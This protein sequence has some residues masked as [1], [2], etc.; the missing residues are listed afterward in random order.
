MLSRRQAVGFFKAACE[1]GQVGEPST[2]CDFAD[3]PMRLCRIFQ[4]SPAARKPP[5]LNE[6]VKRGIYLD[7]SGFPKGA[8]AVRFLGTYRSAVNRAKRVALTK[9]PSGRTSK[10]ALDN[11][12]PMEAKLVTELQTGPGWPFE[13]KWDGFRCLAAKQRNSV[14][15]RGKSGKSLSRYFPEMVEAF[16]VL[17]QKA[18]ILEAN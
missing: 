16:A 8:N 4:A 7:R 17:K 15:L 13:P 3:R 6:T 1:V 12:N 5:C 2:L 10:L 11:I 18:V 14:E 9:E